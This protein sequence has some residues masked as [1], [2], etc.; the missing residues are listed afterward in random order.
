MQ[1]VKLKRRLN[2]HKLKNL[3]DDPIGH[4]LTSVLLA[5]LLVAPASIVLE[6]FANLAHFAATV[7]HGFSG[8]QAFESSQVFLMTF[9]TACGILQTPASFA[10]THRDPCFLCFDSGFNGPIDHVLACILILE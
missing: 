10:G 5:M 7:A 1:N 3:A 4:A 2:A 9:E 6:H 8:D